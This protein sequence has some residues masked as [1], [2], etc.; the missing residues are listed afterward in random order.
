M[1]SVESSGSCCKSSDRL[2]QVRLGALATPQSC[3]SPRAP[4]AGW[5]GIYISVICISFE[6]YYSLKS[7]T[8]GNSRVCLFPCSLW[9]SATP[10]QRESQAPGLTACPLPLLSPSDA[11]PQGQ[12]VFSLFCPSILGAAAA[13]CAVWESLLEEAGMGI[14]YFN[15]RV[16]IFMF[17]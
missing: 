2:G 14:F 6:W 1:L 8:L 13:V 15:S 5:C 12:A 3:P 17:L 7:K 10:V 11:R 16:F 4:Q 9:A